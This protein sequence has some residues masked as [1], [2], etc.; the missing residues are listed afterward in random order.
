MK[1]QDEKGLL[2]YPLFMFFF[3]PIVFLFVTAFTGYEIFH[4]NYINKKGKTKRRIFLSLG[5]LFYLIL[6]LRNAL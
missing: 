4:R 5:S 3:G 6:I 1:L 2:D